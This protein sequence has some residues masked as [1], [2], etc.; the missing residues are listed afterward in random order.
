VWNKWFLLRGFELHSALRFLC[1]YISV[2]KAF[3]QFGICISQKSIIAENFIS[4]CHV[5]D[6]AQNF[7]IEKFISLCHVANLAK[8]SANRAGSRI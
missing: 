4:L 2:N 1:F 6:L 5:A 7:L 3:K 8:N